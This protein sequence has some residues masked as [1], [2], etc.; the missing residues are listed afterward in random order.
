VA[1]LVVGLGSMSMRSKTSDG[2]VTALPQQEAAVDHSTTVDTPAANGVADDLE[3]SGEKDRGGWGGQLRG[4]VAQ[5]YQ[6]LGQ[7]NARSVL[8]GGIVQGVAPV[9]LPLPAYERSVSVRRELVTSD[10][11]LTVGVLYVTSL[12]LLPL[13]AVWFASIMF[14]ARLHA[15]QIARFGRTLRERLARQPEPHAPADAPAAPPPVVA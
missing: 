7:M 2:V 12:G 8:A 3:K 13:L 4:A 10:R 9:A 6:E 15:T 1:A 5:S 11:P 14:L